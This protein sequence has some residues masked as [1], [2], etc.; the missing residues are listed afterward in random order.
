V[1]FINPAFLN[2]FQHIMIKRHFHVRRD[3]RA[4]PANSYGRSLEVDFTETIV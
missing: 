1:E 2:Q 3:N 4:I